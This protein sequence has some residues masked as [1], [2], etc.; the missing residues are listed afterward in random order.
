M[1]GG[2][3]VRLAPMYILV[4][5]EEERGGGG[6]VIPIHSLWRH[7]KSKRVR[8]W[9]AGEAETHLR[10]VYLHLVERIDGDEDVSHARVDLISPIATLE[11]LG[12]RVLKT[13]RVRNVTSET[14]WGGGRKYD[15]CLS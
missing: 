10:S 6:G 3:A 9:C 11:L 4:C 8:V 1:C 13:T 5:Y 7:Y 15:E 2:F 12:D 14:S